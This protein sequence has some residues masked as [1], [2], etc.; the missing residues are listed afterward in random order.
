MSNINWRDPQKLVPTHQH[1]PKGGKISFSSNQV[2][3]QRKHRRHIWRRLFKVLVPI[4]IIV[5]LFLA[6]M[7]AAALFWISKDLPSAD[8]VLKRNIT[9]S[10]KI[11]DRTGQT[12]LYDIHGDIKR[13]VIPLSEVP[14]YMKQAVI[15]AEDRDFYQHHGF[16][17]TG[18]IRSILINITT[19]S[20]VSGSTLTQQFVKNAILTNEKT[21]T[22]K[23]K[24]LLISYQIES[25]FTKDQI[26]GMYLNEIP[27][28]SVIYGV[29]AAAQSYFGK[30][31]KDLTL[32]ESAIL[33][34]IPN[35][36]TYYSPYGNHK[37]KLLQRQRYILDSMAELG[38]VTKE[39]AEEA[40]NEKLTFKPLRESIIAPH[41]V[42]YIKEILSEK[43]G[44]NFIN[45]EGLK[46]YTT[47][48]LEKQKIAEE[49]VKKGVETNGKKYGFTNASLVSLDPKTGQILAMV[50]SA[51][52][53][54]EAIDGQVNV[55]LRSRQPGSSFKPIVYT[56]SFIKGYTP[57]T[58][59]Y[60]TVTNF[61]TTG[62]KAYEP[63]NYHNDES[64]P[65]TLRKALAGSLN[66]PAVKLTY[67][68]GMDNIFNL[69]EKLGYTTF[70]DRS[71][72]GLSIVLGGAEVKLLEHTAA[73]AT[74]ATD[75]I[76]HEVNPILKIEDKNNKIIEEFKDKNE[77]IIDAEVARQTND[78]LSDDSARAYIFGS[79]SRLVLPGRPAAVKTGTTN[80]FHDAWT[81]GYTPSLACGVWVGNND[82]AAMKAG[83][84]GSVIAAPIWNNYMSEA[85]KGQAA[86]EFTK[87]QPVTT[88]KA[89]L[90]GIANSGTMIK[91]D[92]ISGKLATQYTPLSTIKE[93]ATGEVHDILY[94]VDKDA[95]RGP[96]PSHPENDPQY[97][98]WEA[99]VKS[100]AEKNNIITNGQPI[101]TSYDDIHLASDQPQ[102]NII[103]PNDKQTIKDSYIIVNLQG[104]AARGIQ[105]T[106]YLI[107]NQLIDTTS[108]LTT[109]KTLDLSELASGY[110]TLTIIIKDDL[111]NTASK[112]IDFNLIAVNPLPRLDW[113][114]PIDGAT[115]NNFPLA[116][117]ADLTNFDR[118]KQIDLYYLSATSTK[119]NFITTIRPQSD[120]FNFSWKKS[121]DSGDYTIYANIFNLNNKKY[122]SPKLKI[123]IQ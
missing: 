92:T 103:S 36:P 35:A 116:L 75:G 107:D 93:I 4:I 69:A 119:E 87:P 102:L 42:M 101:P 22:R 49:A 43:Y 12:V 17:F 85:L 120:N 110:H 30:P 23:I 122:E 97:Y 100:W 78:I 104:S 61:D 113:T 51:D 7:A 13:T 67:L 15:T 18:I 94:Y 38:Y 50:G 56:T 29:E 46:V 41:F 6:L 111:Q 44:E 99:G 16:S 79:G 20:K 9:V 8:G 73:Y 2:K 14:D 62:E 63:H 81:L 34:A 96:L 70:N 72:F 27:Y 74:L 5:I 25:K 84:D 57:N 31:T 89:V 10:T 64:G 68:T 47:L 39:Q 65:V 109:D 77:E 58:I 55:S 45:Q 66:I 33:A 105:K 91:I 21:Y 28:G 115:I 80:D 11:Y 1:E 53:F 71:R 106:E 52:Y 32:A 3:P 98:N 54:D 76:K 90:D 121:P 83:A 86:E 26:L 48:D 112:S 108:G 114:S 95:P 59:I 19:G 37:D 24:E 123:K 88:G 117:K 60:D 40:K 118:I 82:N